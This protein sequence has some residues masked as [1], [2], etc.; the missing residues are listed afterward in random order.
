MKESKR[1][2]EGI[3]QTMIQGLGME[4]TMRISKQAGGRSLN[5]PLPKTK[6][7]TNLYNYV[8]E[9]DARK[10]IALFGGEALYIPKFS[11]MALRQRN[12]EIIQGYTNGK[13][14]NELAW[15]YGMTNRHI[16]RILGSPA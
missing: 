16:W 10:L 3:M 6:R 4:T 13:S 8:S 12:Q 5:I 9:G 1:P 15:E 11:H 2:G 14:P 7:R